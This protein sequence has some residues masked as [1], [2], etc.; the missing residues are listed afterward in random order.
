MANSVS[1]H[2]KNYI[3]YL[4]SIGHTKEQINEELEKRGSVV[5]PYWL[6]HFISLLEEVYG[7]E[8]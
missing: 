6:D 1:K 8:D 7:E 4:Y 5:S 3:I 2:V